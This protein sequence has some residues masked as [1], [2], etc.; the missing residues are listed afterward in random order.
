M[1]T[2]RFDQVRKTKRLGEHPIY[3]RLVFVDRTGR[4][5]NDSRDKAGV[6]RKGRRGRSLLAQGT[7]QPT[8]R[9]DTEEAGLHLVISAPAFFK[10]RKAGQV[11]GWIPFP[12]IYSFFFAGKGDTA[13]MMDAIVYRG[14]FL[15]IPPAAA[16][17]L[18]GAHPR[19]P[20]ELRPNEPFLLNGPGEGAQ[21]VYTV[22]VPVRDTGFS[23]LTVIPPTGMLN[24]VSPRLYVTRLAGLSA[25]FL[26]AVLL[27]LGLYTRVAV[28]KAHLEDSLLRER[29]EQEKVKL[30][31]QLQQAQKMEAL[32]S[33]AGGIAHDMNNVLAAILSLASSNLEDQPAG[34]RARR[35]FGIIAEAATRGGRMVQGLLNFARQNPAESHRVDLNALLREVVSLLERTTLARVSLKLELAPDL[36]ALQGDAS[37]LTHAFI[38][39]C[40]NAVDAMPDQGRLTLTTRRGEGGT[41]EV[42]V[43]DTGTGM[44]REVMARA[45]DP[46]FTTKAVGKGT[47]LGLAMV[48]STVTA[49]QGR[50]E[51]WSEPGQG[52]RV[53]L[54]FP[55]CPPEGAQ[56][57]P[58]RDALPTQARL[59]AVLVVDDDE[60]IRQS[61]SEVLEYLGHEAILAASGEEA[62]ARLEGGL[63]ADAV[64]LD[65]NM[66]GLGGAG[67]LPR[68]RAL[69]PAL[70]VILS[71]GRTDQST[72]DLAA[73]FPE[74]R[75]LPKPFNILALQQLLAGFASV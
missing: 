73:R 49:H 61:I 57:A 27:L 16:P 38:N 36:P 30:Q 11:L 69:R 68:L 55:A 50:M 59:L 44:P 37:A 64:I 48:Y 33:L 2:D 54:S 70:P 74:V 20:A 47:G 67:T 6:W 14:E 4:I 51:L 66:P 12:E 1:V 23:I 60:L 56:P 24:H 18:P 34:S 21:A 72:L 46:F 75:L 32:G 15:H 17:F 71:T 13:G 31:V 22:L 29:A 7:A 8:I 26:V 9:C 42:I 19:P 10:G 5:L 41:V 53:T 40:V 52:T 58:V 28:L 63:Q 3:D 62:L 25:L 45:M 65:L 43:A 39:L 35:A